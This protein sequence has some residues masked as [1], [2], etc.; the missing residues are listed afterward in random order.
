MSQSTVF[1]AFPYI[2]MMMIMILAVYS[3]VRW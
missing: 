2:L 3:T 1:D